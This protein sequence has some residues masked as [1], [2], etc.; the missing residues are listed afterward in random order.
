MG[1]FANCYRKV[2][3]LLVR[4]VEDGQT[5]QMSFEPAKGGVLVK[6]FTPC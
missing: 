5:F 6:Q 4:L 1:V 3:K 2:G